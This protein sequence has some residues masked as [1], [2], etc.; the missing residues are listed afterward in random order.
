MWLATWKEGPYGQRPESG[1]ASSEAGDAA[2]QTV[3]WMKIFRTPSFLVGAVATMT[4]H[5]LVTSVGYG[6]GAI[7]FP[8]FN[9]GLSQI[10]PPKQLAGTL[11]VF[12]AIQALGGLIAPFLTRV[13][14]DAAASPAAGYA[15]A[16]RVFGI[17][18]AIAAVIAMLTV[19][20]ERDARR[21]LG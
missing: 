17:A 6:M 18:A 13:I 21:V 16:F 5:A 4:M 3:P 12:L 20:P 19:N 7:I 11:G 15:D 2:V 8:L 1:A 14:V 9:A 10:S